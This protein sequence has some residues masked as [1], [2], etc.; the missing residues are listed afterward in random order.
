MKHI[1]VLAFFCV[2]F[3]M[4]GQVDTSAVASCCGGKCTGS[5]YCTACSNC[6][7]CKHCNSGGSCGVCAGGVKWKASPSRSETTKR[8][9]TYGSGTTKTTT[10]E[11]TVEPEQFVAVISQT[12][13]MRSGP[14]TD[15]PV[16][17]VLSKGQLLTIKETVQNGWV[18]VSAN[19][20]EGNVFVTY[21]GYVAAKYVK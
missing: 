18:K 3:S 19:N 14:G 4:Y 9:D 20:L 10:N 15:Y 1:V 17:L 6:S 16:V 13:N 5:A 7:G 12:L 11:T 8:S 21:V 2:C